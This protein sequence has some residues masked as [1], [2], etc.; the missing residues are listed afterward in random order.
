MSDKSVLKADYLQHKDGSLL[1]K[2]NIISLPQNLPVYIS[3][4]LLCNFATI[5]YNN[6]L[7]FFIIV[8]PRLQTYS[9]CF[10][11]TLW[12]LKL[13]F[14]IHTSVYLLGIN[15]LRLISVSVYTKNYLFIV[16]HFSAHFAKHL[17]QLV[18]TL[19][20]AFHWVVKPTNVNGVPAS[21]GSDLLTKLI[22]DYVGGN[23]FYNL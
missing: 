15:G 21:L 9:A 12:P 16:R 6:Y 18:F 14:S 3:L 17:Q 2:M 4:S 1:R 10:T 19:H 13:I 23:N 7:L 5:I 8:Q 20:L 11:T 22:C